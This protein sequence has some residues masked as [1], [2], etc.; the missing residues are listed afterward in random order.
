MTRIFS[1]ALLQI[2]FGVL[3]GTGLAALWGLDSAR[4][5][6]ILLATLGVML[7]VGL[8]ACAMPLWRAL[9]IQP[10]DALRA[11]G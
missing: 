1:R 6:G 10:T 5:V 2:G 3:A 7:T 4:E 8:L 9:R 11:E